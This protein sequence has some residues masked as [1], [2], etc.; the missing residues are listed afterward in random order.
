MKR[1]IVS[2]L[3]IAV[4]TAATLASADP[5]PPLNEAPRGA[6]TETGANRPGDAYRVHEG[7][8]ADA[9]LGTGFSD[10]YGLGLSG[11]LGYAFG[12]GVYLGGAL[13]QFFGSSSSRAT[14][15][16]AEGGYKFFPTLR[17]EVRPY[18]FLGPALVDHGYGPD[19][20]LGFQPSVLTAY[21]FGPW[22]LSA[23]ARL[24]A[25]P[26]PTALALLVGGGAGF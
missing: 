17:W 9:L 8:E 1:A 25:V 18:A 3:T 12:S 21:H 26:Q 13:T 4:A 22:F 15:F 5:P 7:V 19:L 14:F 6:G 24:Y 10:V 11:R 16:G 23:D 20:A 2:A